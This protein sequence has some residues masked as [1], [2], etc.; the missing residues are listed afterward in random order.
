MSDMGSPVVFVIEHLAGEVNPVSWELAAAASHIAQK[1]DK[2]VIGIILG[3]G[4]AKSAEEF[5]EISKV[6]VLAVEVPGLGY[7]G[8]TY[9]EVLDQ[10]LRELHATYVCFGHASVG[11]DVAPA[12][13]L[14]LDAACITGVEQ[15]E[16]EEGRL[17]YTR[18]AYGGKIRQVVVSDRETTILTVQPGSFKFSPS[19]QP[20]P[21]SVKQKS[22]ES[23]PQRSRQLELEE[24]VSED[25]GFAHAEVIVAAGRGIGKCENTELINRFASLFPKSA[26]AGSRPLCDAGWLEYKQQ[27]GQTGATVS[28]MVYI[29][30]GISGAS[31]HQFGMRDSGFIV[32]INTDPNAAIFNIADVCIVEKLT[33]FI[34]AFI[35]E[36]Q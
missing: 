29:A 34:P 5:A 8:E 6:Q 16:A 35:G 14:H 3:E 20:G 19:A 32:A 15:I 9:R 17:L 27:V 10:V 1:T 31:Q 11:M 13:A 26:V 7:L 23:R 21:A 24:T 2:E 36:Y 18:S 12:L 30:C 33:D 28:P 25:A 4:V 22:I